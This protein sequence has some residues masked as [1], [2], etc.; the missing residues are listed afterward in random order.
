MPNDKELRKLPRQWIC[1]IGA[2]VI[3]GPFLNW[4]A[5]RIKARNLAVT[6]DK[7]LLISMD[8]QVFS[9]FQNST[10]VSRK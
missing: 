3:K 6:Q 7:G 5:D 4:V 1:N 9:A 8:P 2:A 10:A